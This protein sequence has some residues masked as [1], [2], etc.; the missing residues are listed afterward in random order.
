M[1]EIE[2]ESFSQLRDDEYFDEVVELLKSIFDPISEIQHKC[3]ETTD[4]LFPTTYSTAVEPPDF[5]SESK[6]VA[7]IYR[8]PRWPRL[9]MGRNDHFPPPFCDHLMIGLAEFL[10]VLIDYPNYDHYPFDPGKPLH[11]ILGIAIDESTYCHR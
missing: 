2:L 10:F 8:W 9:T 7:P 5:I 6:C 1:E 4:L 11:T 3:G